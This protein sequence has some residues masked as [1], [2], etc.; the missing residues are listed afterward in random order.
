MCTTKIISYLLRQ[1]D[2]LACL[3]GKHSAL[4]D[5]ILAWLTGDRRILLIGGEPGH[6]KSLLMGNLIWQHGA[7]AQLYPDLFTPIVVISYDRVHCLFIKRLFELTS[8]DQQNFLPEGETYPAVRKLI[9]SILQNVLCFAFQYLEPKRL[10]I[11]EAPL[12]GHRGEALVDTPSV[13]EADMQVFIMYSPEMWETLL[14]Q[15]QL[16]E[17]KNSAQALAMQQIHDSLLQ[18]RAIRP[19]RE[20]K[21]VELRESWENWLRN[22]EGLVLSWHPIEDKTHFLYTREILSTMR[23]ASDPLLPEVLQDY[24]GDLIDYVLKVQPDLHALARAVR[25]YDQ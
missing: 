8:H 24:T 25:N 15:Q 2:M 23:I 4:K 16:P 17:R 21:D 3:L 14:H 10:I 18:Q 11:L 5:R 6:G 9:T 1:Q 13:W 12:V 19:T 7:L 20:A 22:Y